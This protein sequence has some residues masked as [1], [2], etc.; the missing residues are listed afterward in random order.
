MRAWLSSQRKWIGTWISRFLVLQIFP[1]QIYVNING[2]LVLQNSILTLLL[3]IA[4]NRE[5][6]IKLLTA[7]VSI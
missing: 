6:E 3:K 5:D 7:K 2:M 1:N 4:Y